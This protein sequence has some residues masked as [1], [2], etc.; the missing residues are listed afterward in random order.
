MS[1][2]VTPEGDAVRSEGKKK[3]KGKTTKEMPWNPFH[4][5]LSSWGSDGGD[6]C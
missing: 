2:I 1:C 6:G 3:K 5:R 4:R